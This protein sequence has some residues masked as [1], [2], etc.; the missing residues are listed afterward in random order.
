MNLTF[1][2]LGIGS[3]VA[4]AG[5]AIFGKMGLTGVDSV[6]ATAVRSIIMAILVAT[7]A[8]ATGRLHHL[9]SFPSRALVFTLLSGAAGAA[10]WLLYFRA[11]QIGPAGQLAAL[12]RLS[13]VF[14]LVLAA[15]FLGER[16]T[17]WSILGGI[18]MVA[19]ALLVL[20]PR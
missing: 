5:V 14:V 3:A 9:G 20:T 16:L 2:L 17:E 10:S 1:L 11:L 12:D 7:V 13:V 4:A 19:G 6:T 15:L 8:A 18:L